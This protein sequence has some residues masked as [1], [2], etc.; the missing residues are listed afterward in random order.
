M[1]DVD[2]DA[3]A[4]RFDPFILDLQ[5]RLKQSENPTE[6]WLGGKLT[7]YTYFGLEGL[8]R[9]GP[10][11]YLGTVTSAPDFVVEQQLMCEGNPDRAYSIRLP[12]GASEWGERFLR[13]IMKELRDRICSAP[14]ST[15]AAA[16]RSYPKAFAAS[17]GT[18]LVAQFGFSDPVA[19][20]IAT[21][22]I[23]TVTGSTKDAFCKMTTDQVIAEI[24][25]HT[26]K[27]RDGGEEQSLG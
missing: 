10:L 20:G 12:E 9:D 27:K 2:L 18:A 24:K 8:G 4:P 5:D 15:R 22:V 16:R 13:Q 17:I 6:R 14:A 7:I 1:S 11:Q 3:K 25:A 23:V 19:I 26:C 21:L